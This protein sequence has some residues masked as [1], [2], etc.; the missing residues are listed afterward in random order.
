MK[1]FTLRLLLFFSAVMLLSA[2]HDDDDDSTQ[3]WPESQHTL[4]IYMVGDNDLSHYCR[5]NT[6]ACIQGMLKS[7]TPVNLV[8]YEDSKVSGAKGTPV[9]FQLKR[10]YQN[11]EKVDTIMIKQYDTEMNSADPEVLQQVANEA[12]EKV[13]SAIRGIEIWSHGL[14]WVPGSSYR[15]SSYALGAKTRATQYIGI[16]NSS[17][18]EIWQMRKALETCPHFDY[19]IFDACNMGQAEVAYEL[20]NIADYMLACPTEIMAEGLPYSGMIKSLSSC[21]SK[22]TLINALMQVIDDFAKYYPGSPNAEEWE[23][24]TD[25]GLIALTDLKQITDVHHTFK[26]LLADC[27]EDRADLLDRNFV[28]LQP[29]GQNY[30]G[31]RYLFFDMEG[32]AEVL[33]NNQGLSSYQEF[34]QALKRAIL[35][36]YHSKHFLNFGEMRSCGL[37]VALP[38]FFE[39]SRHPEIT[40]AAYNE[41]QWTKD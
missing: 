36:E 6:Q 22:E 14:G 16:D 37:G 20:R 13:P 12:F 7:E 39:Y 11:K 40:T 10:N 33:D 2:C 9:L 38:E 24:V 8:I 17:Y 30:T 21:Q 19:I 3:E 5:L 41:L 28:K 1:Q 25:G 26:K 27:A 31:T 29:F 32:V 18:M 4:L 15:P 23:E 34:K 35:K